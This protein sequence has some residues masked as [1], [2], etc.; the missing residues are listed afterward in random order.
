[1][2]IEVRIPSPGESISEVELTR[3]LVENG[4]IVSKDQ[5]VAEIE[6]EKATLPIIAPES[7][8][9]NILVGQGSA[10]KVN[11]IAC[12]ID[13]SVADSAEVKDKSVEHPP[14]VKEEVKPRET[15]SN[16]EVTVVEGNIKVTPLAKQIMADSNLSVDDIINGLRRITAQDV[17]LVKN[18]SNQ[19][20]PIPVQSRI[21]TE[22]VEERAKMSQLRKKV[23][24]RLVSVKNQTAMLTTFN[25][26]DMS[27]VMEIRAKYQHEF[28][29]KYGVKLGLM[30][31]FTKAVVE[32]LKLHPMTNSYIDGEEI[33]TP[34]YYDIG[35]AVQAPKGLMVPVLRNVE[36]MSFAQIEQGIQELAN[37]ARSGKITLDELNGGTFTITNGG[38][39]GSML[40]TPIL[41][42][43]QSGILG[44]HNIADRPVA[45]NGKVEIRPIMYVALSYDHRIIDGKDSASFLMDVKRMIENPEAILFG[46]GSLD[47]KLI[48]L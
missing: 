27:R 15:T 9:L 36:G 20:T 5:E 25:E 44:M 3:W 40:S 12:T 43:P 42:P 6:S 13:T 11:A 23:S 1:M 21:S 7:G 39:F 17:E 22:R 4:T 18:Q 41:N 45:V 31:F 32:A 35:V 48:G 37:R 26:V 29:E 19:T 2:I 38:I 46:G 33:V 34:N 14:Q 47:K 16:T 10:V 28:K 8:K 30:S 24:E